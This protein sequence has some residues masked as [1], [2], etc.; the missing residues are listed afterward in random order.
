MY[1]TSK[2]VVLTKEKWK[3]TAIKLIIVGYYHMNQEET[4]KFSGSVKKTKEVLK[5]ER[6]NGS[7]KLNWVFSYIWCTLS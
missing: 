2:N 4:K 7:M 3:G 6:T 1:S 5:L